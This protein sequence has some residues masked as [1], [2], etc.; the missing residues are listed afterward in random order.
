MLPEVEGV[1]RERAQQAHRPEREPTRTAPELPGEGARRERAHDRA[2]H[3]EQEH[4]AVAAQLEQRVCGVDHR[5]GRDVDPLPVDLER[6]EDRV[7]VA[8]GIRRRGPV[9][10]LGQQG[11]LVIHRV[12]RCEL[13]AGVGPERSTRIVERERDRGVHGQQEQTRHERAR[14]PTAHPGGSVGDVLG[15]VRE[16]V[17]DGVGGASSAVPL[18]PRDGRGSA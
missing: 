2:E 5:K 13:A 10:D 8:L 15:G 17:V 7:D 1:D 14:Q 3:R 6:V 12:Q 16:S 4:R 9:A 11:A 18:T